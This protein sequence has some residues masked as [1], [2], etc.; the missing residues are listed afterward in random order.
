MFGRIA[1]SIVLGEISIIINYKQNMDGFSLANH[2]QFAKTSK[3]SRY[4]VCYRCHYIIKYY[5]LLF[6]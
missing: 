6:L 3:H 2:G 4:T 1:K 5:S